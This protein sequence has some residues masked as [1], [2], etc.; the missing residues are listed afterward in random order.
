MFFFPVDGL[1]VVAESTAESS[2][3][4]VEGKPENGQLKYLQKSG[5]AAASRCIASAVK[6]KPRQ[7]SPPGL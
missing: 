4:A 7:L 5:N 1:A 2:R 6:K 3:V